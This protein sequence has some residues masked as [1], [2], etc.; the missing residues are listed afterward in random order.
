M[1][2][3]EKRM[4]HKLGFRHREQ[5]FT[6]VEVLVSISIFAVLMTAMLGFL[7]GISDNW[8]NGKNAADMNENARLGLN[9]MTRE[10]RQSS[11]LITAEPGRIIFKADFG[12][13]VGVETI[14]YWFEP[15]AQGTPGVVKRQDNPPGNTGAQLVMMNNVDTLTFKY[16]GND[17]KCDTNPQNGEVTYPELQACGGIPAKIAR[18]DISL[19]VKAGSQEKQTFVDQAWLRN[20]TF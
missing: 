6:M 15:G 18:V 20:R 19:I 9:R 13:G 7:W 10:I 8:V 5:G 3:R 1:I 14:T 11:Q 16:Y 17:Y 2:N 12:S 4:V